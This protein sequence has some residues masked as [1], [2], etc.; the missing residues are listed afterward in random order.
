MPPPPNITDV[1]NDNG[2]GKE[3]GG[4]NHYCIICQALPPRSP[5]GAATPIFNSYPSGF[6][7]LPS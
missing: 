6:L 5:P 7:L 3:I 1:Q 4:S 2:N